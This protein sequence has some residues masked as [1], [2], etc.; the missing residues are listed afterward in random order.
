MAVM[1]NWDNNTHNRWKCWQLLL[2][3]EA[4]QL[5]LSIDVTVFIKAYLVYIKIKKNFFLCFF[6]YNTYVSHNFIKWSNTLKQFVGK[7]PT[8]CLS[9]FDHFVGLAL[10]GL[11]FWQ[12]LFLYSVTSQLN[13][14]F[15]KDILI[16]VHNYPMSWKCFKNI[17]MCFHIVFS[18][19]LR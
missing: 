10:K 11:S 8:N 5:P 17:Q 6:M 7:F 4:K 2:Q 16:F 15:D 19:I 9:V 1:A 3:I 18:N 13:L 12:D 14:C